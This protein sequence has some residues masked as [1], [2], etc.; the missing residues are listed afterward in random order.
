MSALERDLDRIAAE[1]GFSGVV[2]VD[3]RD[4]LEV[5]RAYGLADRAH[6]NPERRPTR[7]SAIASGTKG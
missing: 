2:R 1:T 7:S 4:G 6:A 5:V 3:G